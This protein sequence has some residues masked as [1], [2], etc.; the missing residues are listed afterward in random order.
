MENKSIYQKCFEC[1]IEQ[2]IHCRA[3]EIYEYR[4]EYGVDGSALSDW[5]EAERE[6]LE[7]IAGGYRSLT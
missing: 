5:L 3:Y 4:M 1:C 7:K 6:V 2:M